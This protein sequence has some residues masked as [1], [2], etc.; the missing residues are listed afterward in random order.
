MGDFVV[1]AD[2]FHGRHVLERNNFEPSVRIVRLIRSSVC[3][4]KDRPLQNK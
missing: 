3:Y 1:L 2:G 4:V